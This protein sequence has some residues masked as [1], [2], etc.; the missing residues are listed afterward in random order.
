MNNQGQPRKA[1]GY[2]RVSTEAQVDGAS[3]DVQKE[4]ICNHCA[5]NNLKLVKIYADPG[6]SAKTANRAGLREMLSDIKDKKHGADVVLAYS[7]NRM[8]RDTASFF[9][10]I[11]SVLRQHKV[12]LRFIQENASSNT[13]QGRLT[14]NLGIVLGQFDND[15]KSETVG[16]NMHSVAAEGWNQSTPPLGFSTTTV[17]V[18]TK[19]HSMLIPDNTHNRATIV[20]DMLQRFSKGDMTVT[21]LSAYAT[22][23]GLLSKNG[24]PLKYK[25]VE[26]MLRNPAYAGFIQS[27]RLTDE[28][29]VKARW[30][31]FINEETYDRNLAILD[32]KKT[33]NC[34][35]KYNKANSTFPLKG[36]LLCPHC[37]R[38]L[39]GSSP[40]GGSGKPS[41]RYHCPN[42]KG[43]PS[44]Q[45][46]V[47]HPLFVELLEDITPNEPALKLFSLVLLRVLKNIIQRTKQDIADKEARL[48]EIEEMKPTI[49]EKVV[50]GQISDEEKQVLFDKFKKEVAQLHLELE[51]SREALGISEN[52]IIRLIEL[53]RQPAVIWN[54]ADYE[55]R[56]LLQQMIFPEGLEFDLCKKIFGTVILS[57]LYSVIP[58]KKGRKPS[59]LSPLVG[60]EGI[61]PSLPRGN[62]ILSL[63][64]LPI[65]P[66]ALKSVKRFQLVL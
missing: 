20:K 3:L 60:E 45:P 27:M 37:Q 19:E 53:M 23:K 33:R 9:G 34:K 29:R 40:I 2:I 35:R 14:Q 6:I 18:G 30:N 48:K 4:A 46:T 15:I 12:E 43:I 32:G 42:C 62:Q 59:N 51:Q 36:L 24:N 7:S 63:A 44:I 38:P 55:S 41:P 66:F 64:R 22:K 39:R 52:G 31:G 58:R 57:P 26:R 49:I 8:S 65:P 17:T 11:F 56:Q 16:D 61:E 50:L 47:L 54:N 10:D 13:A 25:Q 1:Y 21:E 5:A 28:K